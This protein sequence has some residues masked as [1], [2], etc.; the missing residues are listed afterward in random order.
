VRRLHHRNIRQR[1]ILKQPDA[2]ENGRTSESSRSS[3]FAS[4]RLLP[5]RL[6]APPSSHCLSESCIQL[7]VRERQLNAIIHEQINTLLQLELCHTQTRSR[8]ENSP[9]GFVKLSIPL[10]RPCLLIR[11]S[12]SFAPCIAACC[13]CWLQSGLRCSLVDGCGCFFVLLRR[14]GL[15]VRC[16]DCSLSAAAVALFCRAGHGGSCRASTTV[17]SVSPPQSQAACE[18]A[19]SRLVVFDSVSLYAHAS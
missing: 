17:S 19:S 7:N 14:C 16:L 2:R 12:L 6:L 5:F 4:S 3:H 10:P 9:L 13:C 18:R 11:I 15:S 1:R 8:T